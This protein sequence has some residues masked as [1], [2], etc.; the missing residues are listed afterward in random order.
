MAAPRWM[1]LRPIWCPRCEK[2]TDH[3]LSLVRK[4]DP[5]ELPLEPAEPPQGTRYAVTCL[6]CRLIHSWWAKRAST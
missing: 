4:F 3:R 2:V 6:S 5:D 1:N